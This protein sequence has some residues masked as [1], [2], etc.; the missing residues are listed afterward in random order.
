MIVVGVESLPSCS[1]FAARLGNDKPLKT[2]PVHAPCIA[3][4]RRPDDPRTGQ[5]TRRSRVRPQC[6]VHIP[7]AHIVRGRE[8]RPVR[9]EGHEEGIQSV[10]LF[11]FLFLFS[12]SRLKLIML[13]PPPPRTRNACRHVG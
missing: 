9:D 13:L 12:R 6:S 1:I 4:T 7:D 3:R 10:S 2:G 11:C 8:E 5:H